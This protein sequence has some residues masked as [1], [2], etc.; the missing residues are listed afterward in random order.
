M[1][2]SPHLTRYVQEG[3]CVLLAEGSKALWNFSTALK[4][5]KHHELFFSTV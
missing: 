5:K 2:I 4:K 1:K 3:V